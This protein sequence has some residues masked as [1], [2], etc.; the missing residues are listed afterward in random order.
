MDKAVQI[1]YIKRRAIR[2]PNRMAESIMKDDHANFIRQASIHL[3]FQSFINDNVK[4]V[5][6][7]PREHGKTTQS[8]ARIVYEIV[9][10]VNIRIKIVSSAADVAIARGKAVREFFESKWSRAL[11]PHIKS[12]REWADQRFGVKRDVITPESTLECYGLHSKA[13]GGRSDLLIFD[14]PDDE[15]V[16]VS[17]Q[18][19]KR[20]WDRVSNVWLNLLSPTGRAFVFATPWHKGDIS[21]KL[22]ANGWPFLKIPIRGFKPVWAERW[23]HSLLV[24][25]KKDIGSL[26]YS[27][28]Y[29]LRAISDEDAIIRGGWFKRWIDLP[30]FKTIG[31][32]VDPAI[33][34][35]RTDDYSAIGLF[36]LTYSGDIYLIEHVR[37]KMDFPTTLKTVRALADRAVKTYRMKPFIGIESTAYQKALPQQLKKETS[38]PILSLKASTSKFIRTS[39]FAVHAENGRIHLK[40]STKSSKVHPDQHEVYE[41]LVEFP[42]GE[43]DDTVDMMSHGTEMMLKFAGGG[44]EPASVGGR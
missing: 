29:N 40:G 44:N 5:V 13:V 21:H 3:Q 33:G 11:F 36:G 35:K 18:K 6:I 8:L 24:E 32:A 2:N 25:K 34:E 39:R 7:L 23:N 42:S 15:E 38:Y 28:G 1:E 22:I 17:K 4:G 43:H 19:R 27:R 12:G 26:A 14:D 20:N 16:V 41:E 31:I 10:N 9:N 30:K 37:R